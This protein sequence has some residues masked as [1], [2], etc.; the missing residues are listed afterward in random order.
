MTRV[1][2]AE[3]SRF[4]WSLD[5]PCCVSCA[6]KRHHRAYRGLCSR[7]YPIIRKIER[8]DN[9]TFRRRGRYS[10]RSQSDNSFLRQRA[11]N[12]LANLKELERPIV[13]GANGNDI[14]GLLVT[15]AE[16]SG[17][18]SDI[19]DGIH[20]VFSGS[21]EAKNMNRVYEV[22]LRIVESLPSRRARK[23]RAKRPFF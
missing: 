21:I 5:I 4:G 6:T 8:I 12:E 3:I 13:S 1:N 23:L 22:I 10:S 20:Y 17:V 15:L 18:N 7:C 9:G 2:R 11:E 19:L 14:E 16:I